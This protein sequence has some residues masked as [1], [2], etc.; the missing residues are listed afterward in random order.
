MTLNRHS[1]YE[2]FSDLFNCEVISYIDEKSF[3]WWMNVDTSEAY[4]CFSE[5]I[6]SGFHHDT[7][8]VVKTLSDSKVYI[9]RSGSSIYSEEEIF[10]ESKDLFWLGSTLYDLNGNTVSTPGALRFVQV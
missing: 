8:L 7:T 4:K 5:P 1:Y 6:S 3:L 9:N 2:Y 10:P